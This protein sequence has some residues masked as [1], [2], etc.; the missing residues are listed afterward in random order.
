MPLLDRTVEYRKRACNDWMSCEGD[1]EE[2]EVLETDAVLIC[3]CPI[4]PA[5]TGDPHQRFEQ[6][7]SWA[8]HDVHALYELESAYQNKTRH[9][10]NLSK[11]MGQPKIRGRWLSKLECLG[12]GHPSP[13][14]GLCF[15]MAIHILAKAW[16]VAPTKAVINRIKGKANLTRHSGTAWFVSRIS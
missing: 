15:C 2:L 14:L 1:S 10:C 8:R 3:F 4:G 9:A 7:E 11:Q 13:I 5:C 6:V 12:Q 16:E